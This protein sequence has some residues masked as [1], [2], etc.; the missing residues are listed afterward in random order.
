MPK[1]GNCSRH[2]STDYIRVFA[3]DAGDVHACPVCNTPPVMELA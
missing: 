3:D 2:V 1:C